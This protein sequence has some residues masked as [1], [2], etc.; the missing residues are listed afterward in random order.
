M[1]IQPPR[2][3]TLRLW[4]SGPKMAWSIAQSHGRHY[5]VS[6]EPIFHYLPL[7]GNF[8]RSP[9]GEFISSFLLTPITNMKKHRELKPRRRIVSLRIVPTRA[10][11]E[12]TLEKGSRPGYC[13]TPYHLQKRGSDSAPA[14]HKSRGPWFFSEGPHVQSR[15]RPH[16]RPSIVSIIV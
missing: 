7:Y 14:A 16:S 2:P 6:T 5:N 10:L 3:Q 9:V 4:C 13:L 8:N 12:N 1:R 11:C 15:A